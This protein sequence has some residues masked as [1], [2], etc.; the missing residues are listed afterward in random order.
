MFGGW[1]QPPVDEK[2]RTKS[3]IQSRPHPSEATLPS[4]SDEKKNTNGAFMIITF[5]WNSKN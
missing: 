4:D 2:A 5:S 1:R 3:Q